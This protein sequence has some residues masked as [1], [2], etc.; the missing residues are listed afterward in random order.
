M[1]YDQDN[2]MLVPTE[3]FIDPRKSEVIMKIANK[4]GVA[5]EVIMNDVKAR[6]GVYDYAVQLFRKTADKKLLAMRT[7][8]ELNMKYLQ[9]VDESI[10]AYGSVEYG[11]VEERAKSWLN[12]FAKVECKKNSNEENGLCETVQGIAET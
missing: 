12:D 1:K 5:A 11:F 8:V 10:R 7:L 3:S 9:L 4:R 6:A 2:D